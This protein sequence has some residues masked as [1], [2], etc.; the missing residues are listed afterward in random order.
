[1]NEDV[2]FDRIDRDDALA[3]AASVSTQSQALIPAGTG[4]V[5]DRSFG[6]QRVAV[7]RDEARIL[8]KLKALAQ[9]AGEDYFYRFPVWNNKEK[10]KDFIEG[11]SI[12]LANDLARTYGNCDIDT[13][14]V[15]QGDSWLFY[16]RFTDFETGFSQTRAFQQRKEQT[17]MKTDPGRAADIVFQIGQSKAIRNVVLNSLQTFADFTFEEAR[18]SL[19]QRIGARLD[20]YRERLLTRFAETGIELSR[21]QSVIGKA[22]SEWVAPDVARLIAMVKS[23]TDGMATADETF[24]ALSNGGGAKK[25]LTEK[26]DALAAGGNGDP[27]HDPETG[28]II[29][30]QMAADA[31]D[32]KARADALNDPTGE[33]APAENGT[34]KYWADA[35]DIGTQRLLDDARAVARQG[36]AKFKKWH[37]RLTQ[38]H[39]DQLAPYLKQLQAEA[40]EADAGRT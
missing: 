27:P 31:A 1:M 29:T 39:A 38:Q 4:A 16:A 17:A 6:A 36:A 34:V 10:R 15:D 40:A 14:V 33:K 5:Q 21:V 7:Y 11:G 25:S 19:V 28:E 18:N 8:Q 3:G 32:A 22:P 13:R 24:P 20:H 2:D 12:K 9:A 23:I 35:P 30:D 26:L 37:D